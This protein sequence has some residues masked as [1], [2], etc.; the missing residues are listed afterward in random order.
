MWPLLQA[1]FPDTHDGRFHLY[2]TAALSKAWGQGVLHPR[3]FPE[4]GFAYG[5]AVFN[6]YS[7]LSYWPGAALSILGGNP[8]VA[9]KIAVG[10]SPW[11]LR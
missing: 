3:L 11:I 4:F 8:V 7:P 9:T 10:L 2:R 5:Q 1:G 6:Y